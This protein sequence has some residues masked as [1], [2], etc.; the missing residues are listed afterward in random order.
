[1]NNLMWQSTALLMAECGRGIEIIME[2]GV[3]HKVHRDVQRSI[4]EL[5]VGLEDMG[6]VRR[7]WGSVWGSHR[8][9]IDCGK[10]AE[11]M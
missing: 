9:V 2:H 4:L 11:I 10:E 7:V 8:G 3:V 6:M 5:G 1:M